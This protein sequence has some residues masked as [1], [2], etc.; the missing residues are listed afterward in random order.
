M[1]GMKRLTALAVW[2]VLA[3]AAAAAGCGS[4]KILDQT[5]DQ[6][7]AAIQSNDYKAV[8]RLCD[9]ALMT[10]VKLESL[11]DFSRTVNMLGPLRDKTMK[12]IHVS[13]DKTD[14]TYTLLF[15]RGEV[16]LEITL[17]GDKIVSFDFHGEALT[18]AKQK[19]VAEKY[20][21]FGVSSFQFRTESGKQNPGGNLYKAGSKINFQFVVQGMKP[22]EG[23][24]HP[25]VSMKITDSL[26]KVV[27][28]KPDLLNEEVEA[29][30][31]EPPLVTVDGLIALPQ[32][33]TY[34]ILFRIEDG[35]GGRS[36]DYAQ[37]VIVQ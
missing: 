8:S 2:A 35:N 17:R 10:N 29:R 20:A 5:V 27:G 13:P 1:N 31:G 19:V 7:I 18:L 12:S 3:A 23:Q 26:G 30:P 9:P 32:P 36:L 37:S 21:E 28:E 16:T 25:R 33:G 15:D 6:L 4:K 11:D 22:K 14:G 34:N 24:Y